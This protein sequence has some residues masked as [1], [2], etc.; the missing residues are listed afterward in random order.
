VPGPR[1]RVA[2]EVGVVGRGEA[3]R[4]AV[5]G[6]Q[7]GGRRRGRE[8]GR[9]WGWHGVSGVEWEEARRHGR[10]RGEEA[11]GPARGGGVRDGEERQRER[12]RPR[13][14]HEAEARRGGRREVHERVV[15]EHGA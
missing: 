15:A 7:H 3:T 12:P 2:H 9:R 11:R 13:R 10:G 6:R 14:V 1:R 5:R 8:E 4:E